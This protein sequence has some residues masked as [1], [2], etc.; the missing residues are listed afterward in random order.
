MQFGGLHIQNPF[1]SIG[2]FS[3]RYFYDKSERVALVKQPELTF[4]FVSGARI[5]KYPSLDEVSPVAQAT[6]R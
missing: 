4:W 3:T 5:H 2:C 1:F 6:G